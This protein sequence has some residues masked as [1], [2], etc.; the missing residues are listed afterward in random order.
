M[1]AAIYPMP[2]RVRWRRL[3]A[4]TPDRVPHLIEIR[5]N[6][7]GPSERESNPTQVTLSQSAKPA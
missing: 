5:I 7:S 4:G 6:P 2:S 1:S 3:A